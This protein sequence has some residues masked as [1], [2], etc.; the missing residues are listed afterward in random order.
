MTEFDDIHGSLK[1]IAGESLAVLFPPP[2]L[3]LVEG[4][5]PPSGKYD[6]EIHANLCRMRFLGLSNN[7]AARA[8]GIHPSTLSQWL[9]DRPK[10]DADMETAGQLSNAHAAMLLREMMKGGGPTALQAVKFFLSTHAE[11]FRERQTLQIEAGDSLELVNAIRTQMYGLPII[12]VPAE[13]MA[14]VGDRGFGGEAPEDAVL[15]PPPVALPEPIG[16][17]VAPT[18]AEGV[19]SGGRGAEPLLLEVQDL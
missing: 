9:R 13:P 17:P 14:D 12:D 4:G 16:E 10:L 5:S 18:A 11:E 19:P 8:V 6:A 1:A 3:S 2:D 15:P 7:A